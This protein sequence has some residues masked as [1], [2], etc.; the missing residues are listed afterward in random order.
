MYIV[1]LLILL[2]LILLFVLVEDKILILKIISIILISSGV[3]IL[4]FGITIKV[5][6]KITIYYINLSKVTNYILNNF[7][8]ISIIL[9]LLGVF[10]YVMYV[11]MKPKSIT[12]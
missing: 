7:L 2:F 11:I 6:I 8:I 10:S 1:Y 5:L 12:N 9:I 4:V 3:L